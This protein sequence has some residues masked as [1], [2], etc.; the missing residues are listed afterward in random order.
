MSNLPISTGS[1]ALLDFPACGGNWTWWATGWRQTWQGK[2]SLPT[3][4][5]AYVSPGDMYAA[6]SPGTL[7]D[8]WRW[9]ALWVAHFGYIGWSAQSAIEGRST[10]EEGRCQGY[11]CK[12]TDIFPFCLLF[13]V[14]ITFLIS[15]WLLLFKLYY[16]E[17]TDIFL[18]FPHWICFF[19]N[20]TNIGNTFRRIRKFPP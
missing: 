7:C 8:P 12:Y 17:A 11:C 13:I 16:L 1:P 14:S 2:R 10:M 4:P 18:H 20:K 5:R 6:S 9:R 3:A 19:F 15:F